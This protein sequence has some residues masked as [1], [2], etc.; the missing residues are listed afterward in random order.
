MI[1][2]KKGNNVFTVSRGAYNEIFKKQG[3]KEVLGEEVENTKAPTTEPDSGAQ[4]GPEDEDGEAQDGDW[5]DADDPFSEL[6]EK[7]LS[8]WTKKEIKEYAE[9]Y[10]IDLAGVKNIEE[11][12]SIIKEHL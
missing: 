3:Y 4:G 10:E 2:I 12:K 1:Q 8:S 6:R 11:M 9:Y 7:P 5:D